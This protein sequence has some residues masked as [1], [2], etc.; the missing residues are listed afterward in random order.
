VPI[1]VLEQYPQLRRESKYAYVQLIYV[2][3]EASYVI[4]LWPII[5][6]LKGYISLDLES[7]ALLACSNAHTTG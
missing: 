7:V 3:S 5:F 4:L 1:Y 6:C 2:L